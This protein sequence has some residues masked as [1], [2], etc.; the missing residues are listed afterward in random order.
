MR[1]SRRMFLQKMAGTFLAFLGLSGG[2]LAYAHYIEPKRLDI[3]VEEFYHPLIPP[4]FDGMSIVLFSDTHIGFQYTLNQLQRHVAIINSLQPDIVFFTGDLLDHPGQFPKKHVLPD[5]LGKIKAPF[6]KFAVYGNHDHGGYG[7]EIY[8]NIMEKSSF[9]IL[10]NESRKI[11]MINQQR[12]YI[13]GIDDAM[14]GSPNLYETIKKIPENQFTIL[15]SHAPDLADE[16]SLFPIQ[17]Q[18]SGHS[19]GGQIKLP[20]IGALITPPFGTKYPE[21][22]YELTKHHRLTL[23][24]NRGLGTTRLP[25]RF[26]AVPEITKIVLKSVP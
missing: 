2:G 4:S 11:T 13:A 16:A 21:G 3:H 22:R 6:G 14:L 25:Y 12:I 15:L 10:R 8:K 7:T 19:H 5:I 23:Y 17:L 26:F 1:I 20:F 24:V 9:Q 18:L